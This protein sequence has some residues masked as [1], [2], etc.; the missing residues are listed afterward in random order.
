MINLCKK[1]VCPD[2]CPYST[3]YYYLQLIHI[4]DNQKGEYVNCHPGDC[5]PAKKH[6]V[7]NHLLKV[8]P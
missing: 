8:I 2:I 5:H 1:Y 6:Y 4:I 3:P 7:E